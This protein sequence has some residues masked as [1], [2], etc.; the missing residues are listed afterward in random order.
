MLSGHS[1]SERTPIFF[2]MDDVV[3]FWET[4]VTESLSSSKNADACKSISDNFYRYLIENLPPALTK[5]L[6]SDIALLADRVF[7]TDENKSVANALQTA[8]KACN[9]ITPDDKD[10]SYPDFLS[11]LDYRRNTIRDNIPKNAMSMPDIYK[12]LENIKIHYFLGI[13]TL[14]EYFETN[15]Q[16]LLTSATSVFDTMLSECKKIPDYELLHTMVEMHH[17]HETLL[18]A[19]FRDPIRAFYEEARQKL[20]SQDFN[21]AA[22]YYW[23][24]DKVLARAP[25]S[26]RDLDGFF[27]EITVKLLVL[28]FDIHLHVGMKRYK[29]EL[30]QKADESVE[31][32]TEALQKLSPENHPDVFRK[33]SVSF[34]KCAS[35]LTNE[36]DA[37][38]IF[39]KAM[40]LLTRIPLNLLTENDRAY[41]NKLFRGWSRHLINFANTALEEKDYQKALKH[42]DLFLSDKQNKETFQNL[43]TIAEQHEVYMKFVHTLTVLA[44]KKIQERN[45]S[46]ALNYLTKIPEE[47]VSRDIEGHIMK[48]RL[49]TII[50]NKPLTNDEAKIS[51]VPT[52]FEVKRDNSV[53]KTPMP[54]KQT[55]DLQSNRNKSPHLSPEKIAASL[56]RNEFSC[57]HD[58]ANYYSDQNQN[59]LALKYYKLA[60]ECFDSLPPDQ[61]ANIYYCCISDV[62]HFSLK[63][64]HLEDQVYQIDLAISIF[65]RI[66]LEQRMRE[67]KT[68][69]ETVSAEWLK[70][71]REI[72]KA[73]L[74]EKRY[75]DAFNFYKKIFN[76]EAKNEFNALFTKIPKTKVHR[77]Y[78]LILIQLALLEAKKS[79]YKAAL[80]Y[81]DLSKASAKY[82]KRE[83]KSTI[84]K[85]MDDYRL[86]ASQNQS[87]REEKASKPSDSGV[88]LHKIGMA[89]DDH[90]MIAYTPMYF[91][92]RQ[93]A[94]NPTVQPDQRPRAHTR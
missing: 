82:L 50:P 2:N 7:F 86:Q 94:A 8:I 44:A 83:T 25:D 37:A 87:P 26:I 75:L 10:I 31:R 34:Y 64:K 46:E 54:H 70:K 60:E 47:Y 85:L 16:E 41:Y 76:G 36:E 62:Y 42:F 9:K 19:I 73:L 72:G 13:E 11:T 89:R 69:Y 78:A 79:K 23:K 59:T 38:F 21:S 66:P 18:V 71:T 3:L 1:R 80:M 15:N 81:L 93:N 48:C 88:D 84:Q 14:N 61:F 68:F 39:V 20:K 6:S 52:I 45:Y 35:S 77:E 24:A 65:R 56:K 32:A 33:C 67:V 5:K 55:I 4:I 91:K 22:Q 63:Q 28:L 12:A 74:N 58:L 49:E 51:L 92:N 43:Y 57:F 17:L 53:A 29:N 40:F 90:A 27:G 30:P